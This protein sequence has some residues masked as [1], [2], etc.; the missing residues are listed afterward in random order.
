MLNIG[1]KIKLCISN[2]FEMYVAVIYTNTASVLISDIISIPNEFQ[3][4]PYYQ[5]QVKSI[6]LAWHSYKLTLL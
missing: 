6:Q 2:I 5:H 1:E 4:V 3:S